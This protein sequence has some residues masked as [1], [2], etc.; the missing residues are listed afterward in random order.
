M[1]TKKSPEEVVAA[2]TVLKSSS[3]PRIFSAATPKA[4]YRKAMYILELSNIKYLKGQGSEQNWLNFLQYDLLL[5][6]F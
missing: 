2:N 5:E 6:F 3:L 1:L 4:L